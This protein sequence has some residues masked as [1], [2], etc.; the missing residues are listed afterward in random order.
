MGSL[1]SSVVESAVGSLWFLFGPTPIRN[2][3]LELHR[4]V[5]GRRDLYDAIFRAVTLTKD[6]FIKLQRLLDQENPS[7]SARADVASVKA[8]FLRER[9]VP[10]SSY[11]YIRSS[12]T[13]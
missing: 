13:A 9:S 2:W 11:V 4:K 10:L 7:L 6:D 12:T 8:D 5:W 1:F 3:L